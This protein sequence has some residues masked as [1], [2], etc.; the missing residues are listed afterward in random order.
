MTK[1]IDQLNEL[2]ATATVRK[3]QRDEEER[4]ARIEAEQSEIKL[5]KE[6]AESMIPSITKKILRYADD[7][8]YH[9][10][11]VLIQ[12]NGKKK[13]LTPWEAAYA[14]TLTQHFEEQ[15]LTVTQSQSPKGSVHGN[16]YNTFLYI[17]W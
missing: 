3:A 12:S 8:E 5:G 14:L 9:S 17:S 10:T 2:K 11:D 1:L 7:G 16:V 6:H 15:G 4:L 13:E